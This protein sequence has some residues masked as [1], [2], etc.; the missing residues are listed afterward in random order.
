MVGI[1]LVLPQVPHITYLEKS[2]IRKAGNKSKKEGAALSLQ[3]ENF[4]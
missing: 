1:A 3:S 4:L 2:D